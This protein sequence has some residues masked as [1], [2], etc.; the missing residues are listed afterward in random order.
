MTAYWRPGDTVI[1]RYALYERMTRTYAALRDDPV[2]IGGWPYVVLHDTDAETAL[3]LPE[4]TQLW[5]WD[6][7][8]QR[9]RAPITTVGGSVRLLYPGACYDVTAYYDT[10]SGP[11]PWVER[12]FPDAAGSSDG[13]FYGWKVDLVSPFRRTAL[14][15]DVLDEVLDIIV[16]PDRAYRVKDD[17]QFTRLTQLDIYTEDEADTVRRNAQRVARLIE[18]AAPPF[19]D[20]WRTWRPPPGLSPPKSPPDWHH[21][22]LVRERA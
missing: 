8:T 7:D 13:H 12:Y 6:V 15:F 19:T 5:R 2:N 18:S 21:L 20:E 4:G 17:E 16:R 1:L 9:L 11:A 10:G 14:G 22:P 3:Y